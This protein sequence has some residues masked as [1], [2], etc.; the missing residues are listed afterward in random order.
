[1]YASWYLTHQISRSR[2]AHLNDRSLHTSIRCLHVL[3]QQGLQQTAG[4]QL[5]KHV[6]SRHRGIPQECDPSSLQMYQS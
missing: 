2:Q 3:E 5:C 4:M 1:M 6:W